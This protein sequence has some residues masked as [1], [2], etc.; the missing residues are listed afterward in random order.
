MNWLN[1]SEQC[2][3]VIMVTVAKSAAPSQLILH[4]SPYFPIKID[5]IPIVMNLSV[6]PPPKHSSSSYKKNHHNI[7]HPTSSAYHFGLKYLN[8]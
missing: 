5:E 4:K 2:P 7:T 3:Y 8:H 1:H 6:P